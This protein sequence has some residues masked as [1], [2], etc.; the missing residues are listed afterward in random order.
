MDWKVGDMFYWRD[1]N[2]GEYDIIIFEIVGYGRRTDTFFYTY[3]NRKYKEE[4][5]VSKTRLE[6]A[7][8]KLREDESFRLRLST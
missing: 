5:F 3:F 4:F 1:M 2:D 6:K 7:A 8:V